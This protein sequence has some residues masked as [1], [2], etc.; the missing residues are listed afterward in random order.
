MNSTT[1]G[2]GTAFQGWIPSEK[3]LEM[4]NVRKSYDIPIKTRKKNSEQTELAASP[5]RF[6]CPDSGKPVS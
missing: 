4:R 3:A 6:S 2:C 5:S 1:N